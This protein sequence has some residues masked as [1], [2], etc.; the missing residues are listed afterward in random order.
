MSDSVLSW[1]FAA[2]GKPKDITSPAAIAMQESTIHVCTPWNLQL[3]PSGN[4]IILYIAHIATPIKLHKATN[5]T[6]ILMVVTVLTITTTIL[7]K[8]T[9]PLQHDN[10][11]SQQIKPFNCSLYF[12][13][14]PYSL[15]TVTGFTTY[16][17]VV[18]LETAAQRSKTCLA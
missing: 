17:T 7:I 6:A 10:S 16:T 8:T 15:I 1:L 9:T 5:S 2:Q 3:R 4:D 11:T 13:A 12:I 18:Q 14:K